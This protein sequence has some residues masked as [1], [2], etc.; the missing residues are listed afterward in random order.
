MVSSQVAPQST[1]ARVA[2][3]N[4]LE[5]GK[6]LIDVRNPLKDENDARD[7]AEKQKKLYLSGK[8]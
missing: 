3:N 1:F 4:L 2:S 6:L 7:E 5:M 8:Q